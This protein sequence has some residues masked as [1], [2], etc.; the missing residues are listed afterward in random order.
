[1]GH[2]I[3]KRPIKITINKMK[4]TIIIIAFLFIAYYILRPTSK[5]ELKRFKDKD[6]WS[7]MGF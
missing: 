1:L 6:N 3:T 7:N 5:N 2:L 4:I